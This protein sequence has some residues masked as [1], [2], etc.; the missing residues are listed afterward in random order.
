MLKQ[1]KKEKIRK[2]LKKAFFFWSHLDPLS[3]L[4][5]KNSQKKTRIKTTLKQ[6][7]KYFKDFSINST[8][9]LLN[10]N[11]QVKQKELFLLK[12]FLINLDLQ[13]NST[14]HLDFYTFKRFIKTEYLLSKKG[15][16]ESKFLK[17]L[18]CLEDFLN[19]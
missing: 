3:F 9:R 11:Q 10:N 12:Q 18:Y 14:K 13:E 1:E 19:V 6:K 2:K 15:K 16:Q 5:L 4:H 8:F 7:I 17:T